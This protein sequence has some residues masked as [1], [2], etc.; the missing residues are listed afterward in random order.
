MAHAMARWWQVLSWIELLLLL[1]HIDDRNNLIKIFIAIEII[2]A[3]ERSLAFQLT[4]IMF[5]MIYD[6]CM[7]WFCFLVLRNDTLLRLP[8]THSP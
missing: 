4:P 2:D 5:I 1:L 8:G 7:S 3:I 6:A